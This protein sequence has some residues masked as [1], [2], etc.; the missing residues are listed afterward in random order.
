MLGIKSHID[1]KMISKD[2]GSKKASKSCA[3]SKKKLFSKDNK[4]PF[5]VKIKMS[6]AMKKCKQK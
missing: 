6:A 4:L 3:D 2:Y 5:M 1:P